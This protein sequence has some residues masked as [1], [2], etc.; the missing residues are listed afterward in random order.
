MRRASSRAWRIF[1]VRMARFAA[2]WRLAPQLA[3]LLFVAAVGQL[4]GL[5]PIEHALMDLRFRLTERPASGSLVVVEI[6]NRSLQELSVWPWPREFHGALLDRLFAAGADTVGID[7]DFSSHATAAGDAA[8]AAALARA[9]ARAILPVFKQHASLDESASDLSFTLPIAA[10]RD[11]ARLAS[12]SLQPAASGQIRLYSRTES[13]QGQEYPALAAALAGVAPARARDFYVDFGIRPDSIPRISYADLL[14]GA[15]DPT[16][17]AGKRVLVGATAVELGDRSAV[18]LYRVMPGVM[19]QALAYE[20]LAQNR[21]LLRSGPALTFG[22]ALLLAILVGPRFA[23]WSWRKGGVVLL[24]FTLGAFGLATL[25]QLL[26]PLSLDTAAWCLL[27]ALSYA[28]ATARGIDG[29]ARRL[30]RKGMTLLHRTAMM[31]TMIEDAFDGIIVTRE[32]GTI[33]MINPAAS[34][35]LGTPADTLLGCAVGALIDLPGDGRG[36]PLAHA[37]GAVEHD[38]RRPLTTTLRRADGTDLPIELVVWSVELR[39]IRHRL[40]RRKQARRLAIFT[41]RDISERQ[42]AEAAQKAALEQALAADRAKMEFIHNMSHELRTPLNAIIGFS[43]ML[44]EQMLGPLGND[45]Y[46]SYAGDIHRSGGSLLETIN[47]ILDMAR[48]EGGRYELNEDVVDLL[49]LLQRATSAVAA[50]ADPKRIAIIGPD[51]DHSPYLRADERALMQ[52][53]INL[54]SNA[55]K[56]TGEGGRVV[57]ATALDASG[58]CTV[59]IADTGIGM[60]ADE[61]QRALRPFQQADTSLA[62][63]YDGAGLGL[64]IAVGLMALHGGGLDIDSEPGVGTTITLRFPAARLVAPPKALAKAG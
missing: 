21:A 39:P 7:I 27:L 47:N 22:V 12:V 6:D 64:S 45:T 11:H 19:V 53:L 62:R 63:K 55:V 50:S 48:I 37:V 4:G 29:L 43:E 51:A 25:L 54:L 8:L 38:Q 2:L 26:L 57:I 58:D 24:G 31:R 33:E 23:R 30:L 42:R 20:S 32:D 60:S 18:P 14:R 13:W 34:R 56:F 9:D 16:L 17:L 61:V 46:V 44:K 36:I 3:I 10:F 15:V 28:T 59:S 41:F 5:T 40:E 35:L 1:A 52:M 49:E